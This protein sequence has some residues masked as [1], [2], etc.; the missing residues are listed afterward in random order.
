VKIITETSLRDF[1]FWSGAVYTAEHLDYD[2]LDQ[3]EEILESE[4]P[5]GIT[6]TELNDL[7]WFEEDTIADWLGFYDFDALVRAANGEDDEDEDED[8]EEAEEE[9]ELDEDEDED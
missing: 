2:Q 9:E 7:F 5:D 4:Y 1:E 8:E 6:D 3:V